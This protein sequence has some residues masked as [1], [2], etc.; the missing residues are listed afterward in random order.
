MADNDIETSMLFDDDEE[1]IDTGDD[2]ENDDVFF[3]VSRGSVLETQKTPEKPPDD[4]LWSDDAIIDAWS[5]TLNAYI[6]NKGIQSETASATRE[7]EG[8][9][10]EQQNQIMQHLWKAPE[11]HRIGNKSNRNSETDTAKDA[12]LQVLKDWKPK[13]LPIPSWAVDPSEIGNALQEKEAGKT[14]DK[15]CLD[16]PS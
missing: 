5:T 3:V 16:N 12:V 14:H 15:S 8:K 13:S 6:P 9:E 7:G 1:D 10:E 4:L 11:L 2:D